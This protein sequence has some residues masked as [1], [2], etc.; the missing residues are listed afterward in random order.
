MIN[1]K[2]GPKS[3]SCLRQELTNDYHDVIQ[4]DCAILL[5]YTF[6]GDYMN[7]SD[8]EYLVLYQLNNVIQLKQ[9]KLTE[10]V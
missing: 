5:P 7:L 10:I 6:I 4:R 9:I 8:D 1:T 3:A 2:I